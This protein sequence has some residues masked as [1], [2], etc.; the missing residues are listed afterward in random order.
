M[1]K[2]LQRA[3]TPK[4]TFKAGG[5]RFDTPFVHRNY[6][7]APPRFIAPRS[8]DFRDMC[9][10]TSD[11]GATPHCAGFATAGYLEVQN[12]RTLHYPQQVD[13]DAI[14]AAAK[15]LDNLPG[16]GTTL[17]AA[18]RAA[19]VLGIASGDAL[20]VPGSRE[21]LKFAIHQ[22]CVCACGFNVT[23]DW[24]SAAYDGTIPDNGS[25]AVPQGGHAVLCCG[26]NQ[27]GIYIQNSWGFKWGLYGFGFLSWPQFDRQ[28]VSGIVIK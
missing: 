3:F 21:A 1:I 18:A 27:D 9:I 16:D 28:F 12:W 13:G 26:Y 20:D 2:F 5:L 19:H 24:N 17:Q 15:K 10:T 6:L 7:A 14:Y 25:R 8:L 4:T 23:D 11:Q 22:Y